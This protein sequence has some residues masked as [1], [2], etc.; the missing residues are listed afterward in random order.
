ARQTAIELG[1]AGPF[2]EEDLPVLGRPAVAAGSEQQNDFGLALPKCGQPT[3]NCRLSTLCGDA[4]RGREREQ[5]TILGSPFNDF[6]GVHISTS[7]TASGVEM[8][9]FSTDRAK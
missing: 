8:T 6:G 9:I 7:T 5:H 1:D 4:A 3:V 2:V